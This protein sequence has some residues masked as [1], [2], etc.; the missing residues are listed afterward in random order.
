MGLSRDLLN[1][2]KVTSP[3]VVAQQPVGRTSLPL[4]WLGCGFSRSPAPVP[5]SCAVVDPTPGSSP[6]CRS[7]GVCRVEVHT[8]GFSESSKLHSSRITPQAVM[9]L[10]PCGQG[11]RGGTEA[12]VLSPP[13]SALQ[14]GLGAGCSAPWQASLFL[15][16]QNHLSEKE[17]KQDYHRL[18]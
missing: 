11:A 7:S 4:A 9:H 2:W 3:R 18:S 12:P 17:R 10:A 5:F 16:R 1:P 6:Y 8:A 13:A 14:K 15:H